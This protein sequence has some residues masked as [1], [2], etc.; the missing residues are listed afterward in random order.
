[1]RNDILQ[2]DDDLRL[3]PIRLPEDA[4]IAVPWY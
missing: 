3:R 4:S 2:I 1:M